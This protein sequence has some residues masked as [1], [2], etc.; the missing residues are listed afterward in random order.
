MSGSPH[1]TSYL[2]AGVLALAAILG[3]LGVLLPIMDCPKCG[4]GSPPRRAGPWG[5][6]EG[7]DL[8]F[9]RNGRV[10]F[11]EWWK[12]KREQESRQP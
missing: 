2:I 3:I 1:R 12:I 7:C 4:P 9:C 6:T 10:S 11:A 5:F 8:D